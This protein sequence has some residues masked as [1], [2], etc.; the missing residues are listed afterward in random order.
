MLTSIQDGRGYNN[1]T[2]LNDLHRGKLAPRGRF[3]FTCAACSRNPFESA[4]V[5]LNDE[6]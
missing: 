3:A 4:R 1:R 6:V 2:L 5:P